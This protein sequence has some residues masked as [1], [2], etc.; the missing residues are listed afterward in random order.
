MRDKIIERIKAHFGAEGF[1]S[2]AEYEAHVGFLTDQIIAL[3]PDV[4]NLEIEKQMLE[5]ELSDKVEQAEREERER[6][7]GTLYKMTVDSG[8]ETD[9]TL[10]GEKRKLV[11]ICNK[12]RPIINTLQAGQALKDGE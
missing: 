7:G 4:T 10:E 8:A 12:L 9:L 11:F 6:I 1:V 5:E 3:I 2:P